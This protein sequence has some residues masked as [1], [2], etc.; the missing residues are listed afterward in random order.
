MLRDKS[1]KIHVRANEFYTLMK[2]IKEELNKQ[3]DIPCSWTGKLKYQY[4]PTRLIDS[5]RSQ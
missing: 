3:R 1:K 4:F 2:E 5:M